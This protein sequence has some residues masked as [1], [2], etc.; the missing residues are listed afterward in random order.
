MRCAERDARLIREGERAKVWEAERA[1]F[2][3]QG[4][5]WQ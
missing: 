4:R 2:V 3:S 5:R 1:N